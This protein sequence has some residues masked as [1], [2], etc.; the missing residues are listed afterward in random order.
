MFTTSFLDGIIKKTQKYGGK[1]LY[2]VSVSTLGCRV[3]QYESSVIAN[4]LAENGIKIVPFGKECDISIINTC[5]VTAESD[6][7][8]RQL[9]RRGAKSARLGVVVTGCFAE[10][11]PNEVRKIDGVITV[12]GNRNKAVVTNTVNE[13]LSGSYVDSHDIPSEFGPCIGMMTV[14]GRVR[15]FIKIEDGCESKC[16]YCI[17]PKARGPIRSKEP[18]VILEEADILA[19]AGSPEIILTG[20]EVSAYGRDLR[21]GG[22]GYGLSELILDLSKN[23]YIKRIGLGSL[24][25][26]LMTDEFLRKIAGSDKLLRHFHISLQSGSSSV[27]RR[28]RRKYNADQAKV[29]IDRIR[30]Y[31]PD[32]NISADVIVGFP[33]ET[34]EEFEETC[35]FCRDADFLNLHIFPYSIREGTEAAE[36]DMQIPDSEKKRRVDVLEAIHI[37]TREKLM[38]RYVSRECPVHVLFEQKKNGKL[39]GHSEHYVELT[40]NGTSSLVGKICRVIPKSDGTGEIV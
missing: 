19:R 40:A 20:I 39:I 24:D 3:N 12:I 6:R 30:K 22:E 21:Q 29:F 34:A 35:E 16:A 36:M 8:S 38:E 23:E 33:G 14:P 10:I 28:M 18:S 1:S 7:K 25:P 27:L 37:G 32:A 4:T 26:T 13:I 17:I 15:S 31:F 9:I 11:S 2:T 5:T